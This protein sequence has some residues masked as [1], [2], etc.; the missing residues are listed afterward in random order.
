MPTAPSKSAAQNG[1]ISPSAS[2]CIEQMMPD[3]LVEPG[4]EVFLTNS[5]ASAH[6]NAATTTL[7]TAK[8]IVRERERDS[9]DRDPR[10]HE[11]SIQMR[12]MDADK[13]GSGLGL[14]V[15]VALCGSLLGK[16]TRGGTI[17]VGALNLGGGR[18]TV[19]SSSGNTAVAGTLGVT[20]I[21]SVTNNTAS[22]ASNN[23]SARSISRRIP[24]SRPERSAT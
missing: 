15:L 23:A 19:D 7:G 2:R 12:A 6:R 20:G 4:L 17:I 13:T 18:F 21:A 8:R 22:S 14:P 10:E 1:R 3:G 11:F 24:I 9:R 5:G 16:N